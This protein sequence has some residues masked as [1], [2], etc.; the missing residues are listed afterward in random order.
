[1]LSNVALAKGSLQ[2]AKSGGGHLFLATRMQKL[3]TRVQKLHTRR[4][5]RPH[6]Q[7]CVYGFCD[8]GHSP[9]TH[10]LQLCPRRPSE[11]LHSALITQEPP[12]PLG[13]AAV[14]VAQMVL[15]QGCW[16]HYDS[17]SPPCAPG[18]IHGYTI[19]YLHVLHS[20]T[21]PGLGTGL[22]QVLFLLPVLRGPTRPGE[23]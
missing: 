22:S 21:H 2:A 9:S 11:T 15:S 12:G 23:A 1:M 18:C 4:E 16:P 14:P 5:G 7:A 17:Q 8:L 10:K 19:M 3:H 20:P 13:A 6:T